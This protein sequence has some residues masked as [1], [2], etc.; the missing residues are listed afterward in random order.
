MTVI[1]AFPSDKSKILPPNYHELP[2]KFDSSD[3]RDMDEMMKKFLKDQEQKQDNTFRIAPTFIRMLGRRAHVSLQNDVTQQLM[4]SGQKFDLFVLGWFFNDFQLG[5]AGHFQ[6]PSVVIGSLPAMKSLRDLVANPSG[7]PVTPIIGKASRGMP[8]FLQRATNIAAFII[9]FV[10]TEIMNYFIHA[11]YYE[12][13]FPAARNYPSFDEVKRNVS[14]VLVADHFSEGA[15]RA[16]M[17]NI[18]EI[19]GIQTK[20]VP[21]PLPQVRHR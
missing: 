1:T 10:G 20:S 9:E 14:L 2:L 17:P 3:Q 19:G 8:T 4:R 15:P 13:S 5:L 18:R 21:N 7:V 12:L 6:C 11:P 16:N